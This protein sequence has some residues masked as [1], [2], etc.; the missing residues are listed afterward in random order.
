[1]IDSWAMLLGWPAILCAMGLAAAGIVRGKTWPLVVSIVLV[2]PVSLYLSGTPRLNWIG[3]LGPALFVLCALAIRR[4]QK[5]VAW[6][7]LV[8]LAIG[9]GWLAIVVL[10]Q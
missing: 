1:M 9:F 4:D 3:I 7:S 2:L 5:A 8:S 6:V 10:T